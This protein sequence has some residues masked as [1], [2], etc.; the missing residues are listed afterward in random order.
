MV[1]IPAS[2]K[3]AYE[4]ACRIC[5]DIV[6]HETPFV[7]FWR[8]CNGNAWQAAERLVQYWHDRLWLFGPERAFLPMTQTGSGALSPDDCIALQAGHIVWL[9]AVS[10]RTGQDVVFCDRT[11]CLSTASRTQRLRCLFY[12]FQCLSSSSQRRDSTMAQTKGILFCVLLIQPRAAP[13]DLEL[14]R[15]S[16]ALM[17]RSLPVKVGLLTYTYC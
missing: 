2:R 6:R 17:K 11:R 15:T 13:L 16:V 3:Q 10:T 14:I 4:Q 7:R 12:M 5:S 1:W 8:Y 9:P